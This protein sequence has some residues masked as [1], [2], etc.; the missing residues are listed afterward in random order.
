VSKCYLWKCP[1]YL[2]D[3][4]RCYCCCCSL[5]SQ[6]YGSG[7]VFAFLKWR[8]RARWLERSPHCLGLLLLCVA[9]LSSGEVGLEGEID[10]W[11]LDW[12]DPGCA[13]LLVR[14]KRLLL[15]WWLKWWIGSDVNT[16]MKEASVVP[17]HLV[18]I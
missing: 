5:L 3:D 18:C 7:Y 9:R 13:G 17:N 16:L 1:Q 15:T 6:I 4:H 14:G 11:K 12:L 8:R 2:V 10:G